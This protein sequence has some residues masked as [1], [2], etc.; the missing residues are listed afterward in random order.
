MIILS[1]PKRF[2]GSSGEI[3]S[4]SLENWQ[5]AGGV[6]VM[7]GPR[8][9]IE[10]IPVHFDLES[11]V[12]ESAEDDSLLPLFSDLV[13]VVSSDAHPVICYAN[14]DLLFPPIFGEFT[15]RDGGIYFRSTLLPEKF[16]MTGSRWDLEEGQ[17]V[18]WAADGSGSRGALVCEDIIREGRA[19][20]HD[21]DAMD[22]FIFPP[23]IFRELGPAIVG[24]GGYDNA[25]V[26]FC[27]RR[28]IPVIDV[29]REIP[30]LHQFHGHE[31]K[32]GGKKEVYLGAEAMKNRREHDIVH[33]PPNALDADSV[34]DGGKVFP[35]PIRCGVLRRCEVVLRYRFGLKKLS[36]LF[37]GMQRVLGTQE[38]V[39]KTEMDTTRDYI[40]SK[41]PA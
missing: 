31:H 37:R 26:A 19:T 10:S 6:P 33:S 22:F 36:Y 34:L 15:S 27:L 20:L 4:R 9:D 39:W 12:V 7:A 2:D 14:A 24:R 32:E 21:P 16:L 8:Q 17:E 5:W 35:A 3:Q 13:Q 29:S 11:H 1:C 38:D 25:L 30:V 41:G 28:R 40:R 23:S 18:D